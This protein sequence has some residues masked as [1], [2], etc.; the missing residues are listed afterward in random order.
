FPL[1]KWHSQA[2]QLPL[3]K[4]VEIL[5]TSTECQVE[6]IS[7]HENP[8]L[9][10]LQFDNHA[11]TIT[12]VREWI[13]SDQEWL[14][15]IPDLNPEAILDSAAR[16]ETLIGKQFEVMFHNFLELTPT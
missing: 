7:V 1:F 9:V 10:G 3:P 5:A 2:V 13:K 15:Q 4:H 12:N 11:A 14:S 6:A 8:R 16:L